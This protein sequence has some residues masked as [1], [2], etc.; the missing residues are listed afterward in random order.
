MMDFS[1]H[2]KIACLNIFIEYTLINVL[3]NDI[4]SKLSVLHQLFL[5]YTL[6]V[7]LLALLSI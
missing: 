1:A 4:L 7:E 2:H 5:L 3:N 6:P